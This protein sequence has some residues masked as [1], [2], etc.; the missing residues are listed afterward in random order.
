M[1]QEQIKKEEI[2]RK[3]EKKIQE[4]KNKWIEYDEYYIRLQILEGLDNI[5]PIT[6]VKY[7]P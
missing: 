2:D 1:I 4:F 5:L 3:I 7:M 6:P